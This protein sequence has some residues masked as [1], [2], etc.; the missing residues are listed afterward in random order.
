MLIAQHT[1]NNLEVH[2]KKRYSAIPIHRFLLPFIPF[3]F[4]YLALKSVWR[5]SPRG[6]NGE[7]SASFKNGHWKFMK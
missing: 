1:Q 5:L 2:N 6:W 7:Q 3:L 4:F